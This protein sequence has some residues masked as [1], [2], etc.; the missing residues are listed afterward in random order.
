[1]TCHIIHIQGLLH[2]TNFKN[3]LYF[4]TYDLWYRSNIQ[5][6]LFHVLLN[7][8]VPRRAVKWIALL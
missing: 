4:A 1:M 8:I 6:S 7:E 5:C 2:R 3:L